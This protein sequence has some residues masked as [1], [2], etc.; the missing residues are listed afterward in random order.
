MLRVQGLL[1]GKRIRI[2]LIRYQ[3]VVQLL[4]VLVIVGSRETE[5]QMDFS[6]HGITS[7]AKP[8]G[9]YKA[10]VLQSNRLRFSQIIL[11]LVNDE[12]SGAFKLFIVQFKN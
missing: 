6:F 12:K 5:S 10:F 4:L 11:N 9:P 7:M 8:K 3:W 2:I 1:P